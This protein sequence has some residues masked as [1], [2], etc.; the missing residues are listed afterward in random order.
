VAARASQHI[1]L[2]ELPAVRVDEVAERTA[3][4]VF[5]EAVTNA[6]KYAPDAT[7]GVRVS[8]TERSLTIQVSDDGPGGACEAPGHGLTGLR[9]R[10]ED[11]GGAFRVESVRPTGTTVTA[12]LP[13]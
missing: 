11:A 9:E 2:L 5:L 1:Q 8:A 4:Y 6:H 7:I 3:Y 10:V 13:I 12:A